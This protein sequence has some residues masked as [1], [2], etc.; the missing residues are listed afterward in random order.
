MEL[1]VNLTEEIIKEHIRL[2][3]M[4]LGSLEIAISIGAMLSQ[5]KEEAEH[6][7][8]TGWIQENLPF[9][10]RTAQKYMSVFSHK[11]QFHEL[12]ADGLNEAYLLIS[13]VKEEDKDVHIHKNPTQKNENG[14]VDVTPAETITPEEGSHSQKTV[15]DYWDDLGPLIDN[16]EKVWKRLT[17]LRNSTTPESLGHM[18]GNIKDIA[19]SLKSWDPEEIKEC[20]MCDGKGCKVCINGKIGNYRESKF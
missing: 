6:G 7:S 8:F 4:Q 14:M 9:S 2:Q 10:I 15:L 5:K 20:P 3:K 17:G 18:F 13:P 11:K 16:M 12:G 1:V 19:L